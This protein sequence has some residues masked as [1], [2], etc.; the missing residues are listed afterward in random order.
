MN[1]KQIRL[2]HNNAT[3]MTLML[4][5]YLFSLITGITLSILTDSEDSAA[6]FLFDLLICFTVVF[7]SLVGYFNYRLWGYKYSPKFD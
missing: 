5:F 1:D 3:C 4:V 7:I 2:E 6:W